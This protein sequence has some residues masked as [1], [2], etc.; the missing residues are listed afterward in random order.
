MLLAVYMLTS[1]QVELIWRRHQT[2]SEGDTQWTFRCQPH[3][4][5]MLQSVSLCRQLFPYLFITWVCV[6]LFACDSWCLREPFFLIVQGAGVPIPSMSSA[7]P[8]Q[9]QTGNCTEDR[10]AALAELDNELSSSTGSNVHGWETEIIV[11][12]ALFTPGLI[13]CLRSFDLQWSAL[14]STQGHVWSL[15]PQ[16]EVGHMWPHVLDAVWMKISLRPLDVP[17]S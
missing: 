4:L 12:E 14:S 6:C 3:I 13:I 2:F 8:A 11:K 10:Y 7:V 5:E 15:R 17:H 1:F 9:S 16:L